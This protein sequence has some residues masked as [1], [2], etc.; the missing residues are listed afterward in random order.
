MP[1]IDLFSTRNMLE[2][3]ERLPKPK[4]FL[5]DT[6]FKNHETSVTP[7]VEVDFVKGGRKL[8]PYVHEKIGGKIVEN[9]GYTTETF[10]PPLVAPNKVTSA[11]DIMNR[12]AGENPYS[13]QTPAERAIRKVA[14]DFNELEDMITRREEFMCAQALFEGKIDVVGE[15][16]SRVIDFSFENKETLSGTDVW[17]NNASDPLADL[18][19]AKRTI[20]KTGSINPDIVIMSSDVADV[21]IQHPKV[22]DLLDVRNLQIGKIDPQE[23]P[24]GATY[25][26]RLTNLGLDLYEYNEFYLDDFTDEESPTVKSMV[27][28]GTVLVASSSAQNKMAYA[29]VTI[30]GDDDSF[31]TIEAERIPEAWAERRPARQFVQLNSKPLPIPA[32]VN[33]WYLLK[34]IG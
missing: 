32:E 28:E 9:T 25:L 17:N 34:V 22:K 13:T 33:S 24:N 20:Q 2:L 12:S 5:R 31:E 27:P 15:G 6:F 16:L 14:T 23:L 4:T 19:E 10:K 8:A 18:K 11:A 21:F 3:V 1:N 29:A 26:G 30:M 7:S